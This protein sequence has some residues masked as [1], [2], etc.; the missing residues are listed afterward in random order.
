MGRGSEAQAPP[1]GGGP[2]TG[3]DVSSPLGAGP[4]GH[5]AAALAHELRNPLNAMSIH[6][7]LLEGRLGR[8]DGAGARSLQALRDRIARIDAT[9]DRFLAAA[10]PREAERLELPIRDLLQAAAARAASA[11]TAAGAM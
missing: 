2:G 3:A 9:L 5:L 4:F 8:G 7:E 1:G 6:L 10:G 11:A